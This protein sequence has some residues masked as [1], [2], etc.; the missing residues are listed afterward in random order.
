MSTAVTAGKPANRLWAG[1]GY[2]IVVLIWG[3]T[4]FAVG[5]QVNGTSPH[6]AVVLRLAAA[7]LFFFVMLVVLG[8][9]IRLRRDQI[10]RVV[11]QGVCFYGLNFVAVYSAS[12]YLT[13]GVLAVVFSIMVPCNILA[14]WLI[15]RRMP[16]LPLVLATLIG[17]VGISFVF[18]NELART[19]LTSEVY[20]GATLAVFAA[21]VVAMGNVVAA[22]LMT[23]D[24]G[25]VRLNAYGFAAG[26]LAIL[27]WG[28]ATGASWSLEL[29]PSW[30]AGFAY[31]TVVG[32]IAA[33]A[34]Y[35]KILPRVGAIAG[36]YIVVL[37]PVIAVGISALF[38]G[39]PLGV[40]TLAGVVLLLVGHSLLVLRGGQ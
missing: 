19:E 36:A 27:I 9:P 15:E 29:T 32:S 33:H 30:W 6:V 8:M 37:S 23:T 11:V 40:S 3:T 17:V 13:S 21:V 35:I 5:T 14:Q 16:R 38:E 26:T 4:W 20:W 28:L 39:L 10:G 1:L 7:S 18:G 24:I 25:M 22:N 12:Q 31:L 34:I 2:L